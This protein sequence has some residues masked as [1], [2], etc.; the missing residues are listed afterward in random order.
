FPQN[1]GTTS[2]EALWMGVPVL[3]LADRPPVGRIGASLLGAVDMRGWIA[4][5]EHDYIAKAAIA[6][7]DVQ[8][9][10][11]LRAGLRGRCER[12]PLAD[13]ESLTRDM[14]RLYR[15][16]WRAWCATQRAAKSS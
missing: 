12:S 9:L 15:E 1:A 13:V 3:T 5:D 2:F 6:A 11:T 10:A 16:A 7:R 8:A 4:R 14:E